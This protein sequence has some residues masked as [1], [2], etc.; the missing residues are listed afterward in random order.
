MKPR[1][2]PATANTTNN[3]MS[4]SPFGPASILAT[5]NAFRIKAITTPQKAPKIQ[6]TAGIHLTDIHPHRAAMNK[7]TMTIAQA[8][9]VETPDPAIR[10]EITKNTI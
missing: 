8:A 5:N 3:R 7:P 10:N 6:S 4:K 2:P 9:P 1:Y